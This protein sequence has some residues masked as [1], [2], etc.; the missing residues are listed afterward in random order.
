[1]RLGSAIAALVFTVSR[2][3]TPNIIGSVPRPSL[4]AEAIKDAKLLV[5]AVDY[6]HI[7]V[8]WWVTLQG[9]P[10]LVTSSAHRSFPSPKA[11]LIGTHGGM[12]RISE[13]SGSEGSH[14][15]NTGIHRA[16]CQS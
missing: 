3:H 2:T 7:H 4:V 12:N 9:L 16:S 14:P 11:R 1:M 10:G 8:T 5:M 6:L 13:T 15:P